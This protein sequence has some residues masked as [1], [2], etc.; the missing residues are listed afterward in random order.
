MA[1]NRNQIAFEKHAGTSCGS[2]P[3][4]MEDFTLFNWQITCTYLLHSPNGTL[5]IC[6]MRAMLS[7]MF[8]HILNQ[9]TSYK[10]NW[11]LSRL[12][13]NNIYNLMPENKNKKMQ[14]NKMRIKT[15]NSQINFK[16]MK[17]RK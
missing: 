15:L 6:S 10:I 2:P 12:A 3:T 16:I 17:F 11:Q 8:D 5:I 13:T 4:R 1:M 9:T 7:V 14:S